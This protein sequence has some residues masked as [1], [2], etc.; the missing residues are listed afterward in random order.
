MKSSVTKP[1]TAVEQCQ[2]KSRK[3]KYLLKMFGIIKQP[4]VHMRLQKNFS[5]IVVSAAVALVYKKQLVKK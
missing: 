4:E 2:V 5:S 3:N 1:A